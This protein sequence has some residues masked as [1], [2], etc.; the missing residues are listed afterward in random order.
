MN[1]FYFF[2]SK[3]LIDANGNFES[4]DDVLPTILKSTNAAAL[5]SALSFAVLYA[6][7]CITAT[8]SD[9]SSKI[10]YIS[11]LLNKKA[12][13]CQQDLSMFKM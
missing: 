6:D 3:I 8:S 12:N 5:D 2:F 11:H 9:Q 7:H 1:C 13:K 10:T 4:L